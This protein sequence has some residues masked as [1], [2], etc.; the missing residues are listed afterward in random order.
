MKI[1]LVKKRK[2]FYFIIPPAIIE[3]YNLS[4][5]VDLYL[6]NEGILIGAKRKAREG[7]AEQLSA[8]AAEGQIPDG[9]LS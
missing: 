3:R 7:W 6:T 2:S 5:I 8:A 4:N 9:E 1:K